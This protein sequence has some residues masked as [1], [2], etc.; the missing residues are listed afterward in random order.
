M[1]FKISVFKNFVRFTWKH[2]WRSLFFNK[3]ADLRSSTLLEKRLWQRC[4]PLNFAK[5]LRTPCFRAPPVAASDNSHTKR[6]YSTSFP[7]TC[8]AE[9]QNNFHSKRLSYYSLLN[10]MLPVFS[11]PDLIK[12]ISIKV[13]QSLELFLLPANFNK[14]SR[15]MERQKLNNL[16]FNNICKDNFMKWK[17]LVR[18]L[19]AILFK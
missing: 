8:C 2:L 9:Y 19:K 12:L 4:F 18:D 6:S 15:P 11:F 5:F 17:K 3:V 16:Y 13:S 10:K 7:W 1:F 14:F